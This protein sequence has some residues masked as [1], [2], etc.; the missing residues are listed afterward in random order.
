MNTPEK[1]Q[2]GV[3]FVWTQVKLNSDK[4]KKKLNLEYHCFR[5]VKQCHWEEEYNELEGEPCGHLHTNIWSEKTIRQIW[6]YRRSY[7]SKKHHNTKT[8]IT[9]NPEKSIWIYGQLKT[10]LQAGSMQQS[11]PNS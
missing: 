6:N 3:A 9:L 5:R 4:K 7:F 11:Y 10:I 2:M 8:K 1:Y